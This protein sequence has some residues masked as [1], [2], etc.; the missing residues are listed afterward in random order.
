MEYS[1]LD[2][3]KSSKGSELYQ[4]TMMDKLVRIADSLFAI[5][6][7][8]LHFTQDV[9]DR[10]RYIQIQKIAASILAEKS[11]LDFDKIIDLF[12]EESGYATPKV[13]VRGAVFKD[14][15]I[16]LVKERSDERWSLPGGWVD[17]NDSPSE[18][19]CKEIFEESGFETKAIKL[20]A[21][22]DNNKHPHPP[23][24]RH[25]YKSFFICELIGGKKTPSIE[26]SA[27]DFFERDKLPELSLIRVLKSQIERAFEHKQDMTLPTDFD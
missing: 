18:A 4:G 20:I 19:V 7:N 2:Y 27:V 13:D 12:R 15:K 9:F 10:E 26:T 22:F 1:D 23:Q 24:L 5:A 17:I 16:L 25:I 8:G 11:H 6:Q 21:L 3:T 14:N